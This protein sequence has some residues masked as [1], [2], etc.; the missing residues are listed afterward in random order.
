MAY[1]LKIFK[2]NPNNLKNHKKA[3]TES[4]ERNEKPQYN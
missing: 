4:E 1:N 3:E 2:N